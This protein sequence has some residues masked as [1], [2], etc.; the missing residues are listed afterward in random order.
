MEKIKKIAALQGKSVSALVR[1]QLERFLG[2]ENKYREI[3]QRISAIAEE[4]RGVLKRWKRADL[5]NV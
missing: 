5:Y 3:H 1:E 4:N 2:E